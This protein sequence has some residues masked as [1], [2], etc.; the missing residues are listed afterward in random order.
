MKRARSTNPLTAALLVLIAVACAVTLYH[1]LWP[2]RAPTL[3]P[4][5][6]E[7]EVTQ[8]DAP[9]PIAGLGVP[10]FDHYAEIVDRTVF[11][12]DRRKPPPEQTEVSEEP[13]DEPP[14]LEPPAYDLIGVVTTP[15]RNLALLRPRS[16][17]DVV[18]LPVGAELE[19]WRITNIDNTNLSVENAGRTLNI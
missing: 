19:G 18:R 9:I 3:P 15:D 5:P 12:E 1:V 2:V 16:G 10:P 14:P 13:D 6:P 8:S 17:G 7:V 11:R 4:T